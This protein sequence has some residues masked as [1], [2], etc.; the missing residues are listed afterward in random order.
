MPLQLCSGLL[1]KSSVL[2]RENVGICLA[3]V[4]IHEKT[5]HIALKYFWGKATITNYNLGTIAPA[6]LKSLAR[7][8]KEIWEKITRIAC[9][10]ILQKIVMNIATY[11]AHRSPYTHRLW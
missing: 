5:M 10:K 4:T 11:I 8:V 7:V 3:Y 6:N 2:T 9:T 1:L